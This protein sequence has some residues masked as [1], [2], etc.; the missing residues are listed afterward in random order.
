METG[1][2]DDFLTLLLL[3]GHPQVNL[4]A[5]TVTPGSPYQIGLVRQALAWFDV[6]LP[7]G[8]YN[9]EHPK[10]C[11]SDWHYEV[12]GDIPPS[13]NAEPGDEILKQY[14]DENTTLIAGGPLKNLGKALKSDGNFKL[15]R[16]VVQGGFA[17]E[18]VVPRELQLEKFKGMETCPSYNLNGDPKS[19]LAALS[20]PGIGVRRFVSKNVCHG[21]CY[22]RNMH[23]HFQ[24]IKDN[25]LSLYYIWKGMGTY[26]K[27][28]P[29][30]KIFHDPLAAC[31]AIDESI[32][33]WAEVEIYRSKGKWGARL[34]PGS[35]T[36]I[37]TD[38]D[39]EK[40]IST[41]TAY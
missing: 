20:Y 37:I 35:N 13:Y 9:I 17:G 5:V 36:W 28:N 29:L 12:Y 33:T 15:G 41:L 39:R 21:V 14:C 7:V 4:K 23:E 27:K 26:L 10:V 18:G 11:V 2:P 22:D 1:D 34:F 3:L 16:L 30:G 32:G 31:C 19:A 25:S 8:A 40:F 6:D 24:L 38:C